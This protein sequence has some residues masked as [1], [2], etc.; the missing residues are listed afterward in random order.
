MKHSKA[1]GLSALT[2]LLSLGACSSSTSPDGRLSD[3]RARWNAASLTTYDYEFTQSCFCVPTAL[4]PVLVRVVKNV[5]VGAVRVSDG[6]TLPVEDL[7]FF[8]TVD[9][10]FDRLQR[11]VDQDPDV[12]EVTFD[13][14]LG[15]PTTANVDISFM[16]AD[17]EYSFTASSLA[18]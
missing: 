7:A 12:F 5:V 18:P 16:I 17:E 9:E 13:D 1:T 8:S 10:L 14:A 4:E 6:Q 11:S 15:Y 3:A 2:L